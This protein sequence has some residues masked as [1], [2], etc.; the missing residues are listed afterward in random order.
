MDGENES[1]YPEVIFSI[2]YLN[3]DSRF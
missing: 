3:I 2:G 1:R